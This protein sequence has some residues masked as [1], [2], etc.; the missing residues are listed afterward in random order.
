MKVCACIDTK[1]DIEIFI[2]V[3]MCECVCV[4]IHA[5]LCAY[6]YFQPLSVKRV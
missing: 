2:D 6:I 5:Y 1:L 4:C 3:C